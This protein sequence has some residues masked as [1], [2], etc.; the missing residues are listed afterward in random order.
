MDPETVTMRLPMFVRIFA[1]FRISSGSEKGTMK[2]KYAYSRTLS[3][4]ERQAYMILSNTAHIPP[5]PQ[6]DAEEIPAG[7]LLIYRALIVYWSHA[8]KLLK[9]SAPGIDQAIKREIQA[10]FKILL[11]F[12]DAYLSI[13]TPEARVLLTKPMEEFRRS[14]A[15]ANNYE[16]MMKA[17]ESAWKFRDAMFM[18]LLFLRKTPEDTVSGIAQYSARSGTTEEDKIYALYLLSL[19]KEF[20]GCQLKQA[21]WILRHTPDRDNKPR[22]WADVLNRIRK[23]KHRWR[24][25]ARKCRKININFRAHYSVYRPK[26]S[27]RLF[28]AYASGAEVF[29]RQSQYPHP[30]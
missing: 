24:R 28:G 6:F 21:K 13:C 17:R 1:L 5:A 11:Q 4:E 7:A 19:G 23:I 12:A 26:L 30:F 8:E 27:E 29:E 9:D 18:S 15:A 16:A 25:L 3:P 22:D 20:S 10:F 14:L 2:G